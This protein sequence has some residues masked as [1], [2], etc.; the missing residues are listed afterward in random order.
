MAQSQEP[1][2]QGDSGRRMRTWH[3]CTASASSAISSWV[4][5]LRQ[6]RSLLPAPFLAVLTESNPPGLSLVTLSL[7]GSG[8]GEGLVGRVRRLSHEMGLFGGKGVPWRW[9]VNQGASPV[10]AGH[11]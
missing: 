11:T 10:L 5:A 2:W 6:V 9:P 7:S 1:F 8:H 3:F 4:P